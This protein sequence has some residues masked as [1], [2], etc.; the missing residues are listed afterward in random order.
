MTGF[1]QNNNPSKPLVLSFHGTSGTGKNLVSKMIVDN[2]YY[3]RKDSCHVKWFM[4]DA[5]F[6]DPSRMQ[7]Y[8]SELQQQIK[9]AVRSCEHTMFIFDEAD[10][11]DPQLIRTVQSFLGSRGLW[12]TTLTDK[13]LVDFYV[14][15]LPLEYEHILQ[16]AMAEMAT[17]RQTINRGIAARLARDLQY[18]PKEEKLFAVSGCKKIANQLPF[19]MS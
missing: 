4:P 8:K 2:L 11:M 17:N 13:N 1:T 19:Y 16:C 15:F 6:P 7:T 12:H 9:D 14:P 5:R 10:K 18:F 3:Q